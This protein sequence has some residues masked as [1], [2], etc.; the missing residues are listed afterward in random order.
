MQSHLLQ[1]SLVTVLMITL[2]GCGRTTEHVF[3]DNTNKCSSPKILIVFNDVQNNGDNA[4]NISPMEVKSALLQAFNEN[5]CIGITP[6]GD[7]VASAVYS[8]HITTNS[9]NKILYSNSKTAISTHITLDIKNPSGQQTIN[10]DGNFELSS[11]KVLGVGSSNQINLADK[12]YTLSVA[13]RS[14][15]KALSDTLLNSAGSTT[16]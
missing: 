9:D 15:A 14:L 13:S 2:L 8:T 5:G 6:S 7:N 11:D 10:G 1:L 16:P 4:L 3:I 12:T